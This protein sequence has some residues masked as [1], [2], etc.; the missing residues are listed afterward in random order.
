M[1]MSR[2]IVIT[3]FLFGYVI[4]D[5]VHNV[6]SGFISEVAAE[7]GGM[8]YLDLRRDRDFKKAVRSI[9]D[10][11]CTVRLSGGYVE[12]DYIY[13]LNGDLSC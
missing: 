3:A 2:L 9:V 6:K 11:D 13:G 5:L 1:K 10:S 12:S 4:S 8:S 7:V